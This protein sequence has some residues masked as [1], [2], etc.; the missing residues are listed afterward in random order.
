MSRPIKFRAWDLHEK[1]FTTTWS[2]NARGDVF[3]NDREYEDNIP[4]LDLELQQFTGLLDK[5]GVEIYEGDVV[6]IGDAKKEH[7]EV[8]R[9]VSSTNWNGNCAGVGFVDHATLYNTTVEVIGN[10][11]ENPELL[12]S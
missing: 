8:I 6:Q 5:N 3:A 7:V 11:Y 12:K 4:Q 1:K 10:I 2:M 9:W